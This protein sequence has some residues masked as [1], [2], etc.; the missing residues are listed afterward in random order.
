MGMWERKYYSRLIVNIHLLPCIINQ[1]IY[2]LT[3]WLVGTNNCTA[4]L[5]GGGFGE[6]VLFRQWT[7][8]RD[9][10]GGGRYP[11]WRLLFSTAVYRY[12]RLERGRRTPCRD[13]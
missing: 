11:K 9:G 2:A 13:L 8:G 6:G 10:G 4:C 3:R 1:T 5:G 7:F 12:Y